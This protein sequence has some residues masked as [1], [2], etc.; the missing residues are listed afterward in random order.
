MLVYNIVTAF[1][2]CTDLSQY[3]FFHDLIIWDPCYFM[4][5]IIIIFSCRETLR[6]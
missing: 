6:I 2:I 3:Q 1:F 4:K 5:Y